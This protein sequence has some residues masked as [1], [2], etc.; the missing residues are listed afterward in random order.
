[1]FSLKKGPSNAS[2][3]FN[4]HLGVYGLFSMVI[5]LYSYLSF[6]SRQFGRED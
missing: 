4:S 6:E 1:M 3:Y 5:C 2:D